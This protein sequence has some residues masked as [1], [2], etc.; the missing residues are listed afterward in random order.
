M[1]A[2]YEAAGTIAVVVVCMML[3]VWAVRRY[4]QRRR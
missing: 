4:R 2:D 1:A 3:L